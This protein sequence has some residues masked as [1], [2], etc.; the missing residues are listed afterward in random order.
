MIFRDYDGTLDGLF[1]IVHEMSLRVVNLETRVA[2]LETAI[3]DRDE[4]ED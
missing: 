4:E 3:G 2:D 1:D